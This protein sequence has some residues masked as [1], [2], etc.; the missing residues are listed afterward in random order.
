MQNLPLFARIRGR[1][2]LVV[3]GGAVATRRVEQLLSAGARITVVAPDLSAGILDLADAGQISTRRERFDGTLPDDCWLVV[4]A[5]G[6]RAVNQT[7]AGAAEAARLFC[8]V[9]DDPELCT[10]IMPTIVD[11]DPV[12]IAIS[13][14][15]SSPVLARWI[16][17]NP[18]VLLLDDPTQGVDVGARAEIYGLLRRVADA[19]GAVLVVSSDFDELPP[20]CDSVVVLQRGR[21][22]TEV[23]GEELDGDRLHELAYRREQVL[24]GD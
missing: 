4:A 14:A 10:F 20:L 15:G 22:V 21:L 13:S 11:R 2:C 5:T 12:T 19:G 8:N 3:G 9:V 6:D 24:A 7:V 17:S 23:S 18:R 16:R 1:H